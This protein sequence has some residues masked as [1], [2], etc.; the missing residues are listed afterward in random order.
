VAKQTWGEF[1]DLISAGV[2]VSMA[3]SRG[4]ADGKVMVLVYPYP[5]EGPDPG[6]MS[7]YMLKWK[8]ATKLAMA[9]KDVAGR[10][11]NGAVVEGTN[12]MPVMFNLGQGGEWDPGIRL[13]VTEDD[14]INWGTHLLRG[15]EFACQEPRLVVASKRR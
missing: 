4:G 15:A 13:V 3:A 7:R 9:L 14:C 1:V 8:D 5:H 10:I 12:Y 2:R 6:F 11:H